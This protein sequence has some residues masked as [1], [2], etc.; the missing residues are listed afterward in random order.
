MNKG[1]YIFIIALVVLL[2]TNTAKAQRAENFFI[3]D[4]A[5]NLYP[6]SAYDSL[7]KVKSIILSPYKN[8]GIIEGY[9]ISAATVN[10]NTVPFV[11][12]KKK[13]NLSEIFTTDNTVLQIG[14]NIPKYK[15]TDLE[16][17][18]YNSDS[19]KGKVVVLNFWFKTCGPCKQEMPYLN[20]LVDYYKSNDNVKFIAVGL[21]DSVACGIFLQRLNFIYHIVPNGRD[22]AQSW[23]IS[24]FPTNIIIN[25]QGKI[26]L[27]CE[28]YA[29]GI[30]NYLNE[31]I[32]QGLGK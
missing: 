31:G 18:K 16:G 3:Q 19:L 12:E 20:G 13:Y 4:S 32:K 24:S 10:T 28:G 8:N 11:P 15:F 25:K 30:E 26:I 5:G 21:D 22:L 23:Q 29:H 6:Q 17:N 9:L 1:I 2:N 27:Y 14:G 7:S